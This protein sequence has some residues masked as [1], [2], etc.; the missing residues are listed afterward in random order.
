MFCVPRV[1]LRSL[2]HR[3]GRLSPSAATLERLEALLDLGAPLGGR[4]VG[5]LAASGFLVWAPFS[6]KSLIALA[7]RH[8]AG[9]RSGADQA[10]I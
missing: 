8:G 5:A 6:H 2:S 1:L 3:L 7:L 9:P 4:L 10:A